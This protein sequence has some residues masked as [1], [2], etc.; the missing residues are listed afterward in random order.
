MEEMDRERRKGGLCV[1]GKL[2]YRWV[3]AACAYYCLSK[4][5]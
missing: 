5:L 1:W 3:G 4:H 2:W